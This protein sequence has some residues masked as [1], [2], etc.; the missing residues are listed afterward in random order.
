MRSSW[1]IREAVRENAISD[2]QTSGAGSFHRKRSPS[3][4]E[5]GI[6]KTH[7]R[8]GQPLPYRGYATIRSPPHRKVPAR[9]P[10][11]I[12]GKVTNNPSTTIVVPLPLH[13]GGGFRIYIRQRNLPFPAAPQGATARCH[14]KVPINLF[15]K[16]RSF[17]WGCALVLGQGRC[18]ARRRCGRRR[19]ARLPSPLLCFALLCFALLCF[20][21]L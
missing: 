16:K 1:G 7:K 6:F 11:P 13:K 17:G 10:R 12:N 21:L 20:A 5:G 18:G 9:C 19:F 2:L 8:E 4:P 14:R 3:L 15:S